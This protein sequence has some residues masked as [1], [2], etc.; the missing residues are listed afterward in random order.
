[1]QIGDANGK[2]GKQKSKRPDLKAVSKAS[3]KFRARYIICI[4]GFQ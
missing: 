4:K 2:D 1:M 3:F